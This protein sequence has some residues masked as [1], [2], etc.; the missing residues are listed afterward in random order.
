MKSSLLL[1]PFLISVIAVVF[2][3]CG[4]GDDTS[5]PSPTNTP[6][7]APATATSAPATATSVPPT[8]APDTPAPSAGGD[9]VAGA[10]LFTSSLPIACSVC[11]AVDESVGI[12]PGQG[13]IASKAGN[14]V[15]GVSAEDYLRESIVDPIA[16]VVPDFAPTMPPNFAETLTP[17]Q[18]DD[19]VAYLLTLE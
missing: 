1:V 13:G 7:S 18:V 9:P 10:A 19:L 15:S 8:A 12:G 6:S 5:A 16:F 11:H 2:V 14:R 17:Q 4:G 3:A